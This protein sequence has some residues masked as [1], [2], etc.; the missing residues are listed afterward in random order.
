MFGSLERS[1][2]AAHQNPVLLDH[3]QERVWERRENDPADAFFDRGP[4]LGRVG[5]QAPGVSICG[6][7]T[8][9]HRHRAFGVPT[10]RFPQF[11]AGFDRQYDA[12]ESTRVSGRGSCIYEQVEFVL[13][14]AG[15]DHRRAASHGREPS[16][17]LCDPSR[18]DLRG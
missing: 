18:V 10:S 6:D 15:L 4:T 5:H 12:H 1:A 16:L 13:D 9:G 14:F 2:K 7:E 3:V 8:T 17:R 11:V